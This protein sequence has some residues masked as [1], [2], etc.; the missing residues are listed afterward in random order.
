[1]S[2]KVL[3]S[4]RP[5]RPNEH[6][7]KPTSLSLFLSLGASL[8]GAVMRLLERCTIYCHLTVAAQLTYALVSMFLV[9][10]DAA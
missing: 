3:C 8:V 5:N 6:V 1:M 10:I 2:N 7:Q 4:R 9:I